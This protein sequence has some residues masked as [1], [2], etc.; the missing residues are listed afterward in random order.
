MIVRP[1]P[2]KD[3]EELLSI[4]GRIRPFVAVQ[5]VA[6][7]GTSVNERSQTEDQIND[8]VNTFRHANVVVN[9]SSTVTLDAALFD[10]PVVN[11]NFDPEPG[12]PNEYLVKDINQ[13]WEH[14]RAVVSSGGVWT[15]DDRR[16]L[17]NAVREYLRD[18]SRHTD[19]RKWICNHVCG[20]ADGRCGER[21]ADAILD[22]V[23]A[24]GA[25]AIRSYGQRVGARC[26]HVRAHPPSEFGAVAQ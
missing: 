6:Q 20:Y 10:K 15:V 14:L 26:S 25:D 19:Q 3:K 16:E 18:P 11:L 17:L 9:L 8:W 7:R 22:A 12:R 5:C 21:L 13:T 24:R 4:F 23:D 2:A 1:H